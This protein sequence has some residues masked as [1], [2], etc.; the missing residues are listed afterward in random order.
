MAWRDIPAPS[1]CRL[2]TSFLPTPASR[3]NTALI[4]RNAIES[5]YNQLPHHIGA[6]SGMTKHIGILMRYQLMQCKSTF[7]Q[8]NTNEYG[9]FEAL[10]IGNSLGY[11]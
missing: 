4:P 9:H 8:T 6:F 3:D 7:R 11:W 1:L 10:S 2:L 5:Q